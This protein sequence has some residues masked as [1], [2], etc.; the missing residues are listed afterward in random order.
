MEKK[1]AYYNIYAFVPLWCILKITGV[2]SFSSVDIISYPLSSLLLGFQSF[3][4][5][6]NL[7][8]RFIGNPRKDP[9]WQIGSVNMMYFGGMMFT[10]I[11]INYYRKFTY[12]I[13][14][15]NIMQYAYYI[16]AMYLFS[17]QRDI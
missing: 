8:K 5:I 7:D 16:Y 14:L 4:F 2:E 11:L 13:Y 6:V 3:Q 9:R 12:I 15:L 17:K 10:Y 1:Y